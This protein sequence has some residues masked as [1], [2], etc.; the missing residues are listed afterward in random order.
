MNTDSD[1]IFQVPTENPMFCVIGKFND[2]QNFYRALMLGF[3]FDE[4][5]IQFYLIDNTILLPDYHK[6]FFN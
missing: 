6:R 5:K 3:G 2:Y 1:L 4:A